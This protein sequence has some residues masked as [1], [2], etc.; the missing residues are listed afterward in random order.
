[1]SDKDLLTRWVVEA[2]NVLGGEA[3][4]VEVS[5]WVWENKE[6]E[7][8]ANGDLLYKWQYDIRWAAQTLRNRGVLRPKDG[9]RG[10]PWQLADPKSSS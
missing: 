7:L 6:T 2:L 8:R 10:G 9:R 3:T 4:V 1:M 5:R